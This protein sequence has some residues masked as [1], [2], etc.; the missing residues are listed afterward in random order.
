MTDLLTNSILVALS[1]W[2]FSQERAQ[3]HSDVLTGLQLLIKFQKENIDAQGEQLF[4]LQNM[5]G[6][7]LKAFDVWNF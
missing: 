4:K 1:L 5:V 6:W 2:L 7:L 3:E